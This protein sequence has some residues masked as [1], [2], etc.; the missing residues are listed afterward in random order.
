MNDTRSPATDSASSVATRARARTL[1]ARYAPQLLLVI[2]IIA[3]LIIKP[4]TLSGSNILDILVDAAPIAVL[5]LGAMWVLIGGGLDLSAGYGVA[6]CAL[7][8]ATALQHGHSL[9]LAIGEA[10][11]AGIAL[12]LVNGLLVGVIGMPAFIATLAT[13]VGVEGITLVLGNIGTV[14]IDNG[15]LTT[16]GIQSV[17]GVPIPIIYAAGFALIVWLLSRFTRFGLRT[18]SI[19]SN[20]TATAARGVPI[21]RQTLLI[22]V[23]GGIMTAA[24]AVLLVAHVQVVDPNIAGIDLLLDAFAATILGG[25]SLFGGRGSVVGT[26]TGAAIISLITT[27]LVTLGVG[28]QDVDLLKGVMIVVAVIVDALVRALERR[29]AKTQAVPA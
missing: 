8:L 21:V 16:L 20:R 26:I 3:F 6:M 5:G 18:Y 29:G 4:S 2:A 13:M 19:G 15:V 9:P 7:V 12:G 28:P 10:L 14:I 11:G 27:G 1:T 25:T 17:V 22:Y 23:F 24:T